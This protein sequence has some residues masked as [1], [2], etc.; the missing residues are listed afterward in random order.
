MDRITDQLGNVDLLVLRSWSAKD[1]GTC[2]GIIIVMGYHKCEELVFQGLEVRGS[3][4]ADTGHISAGG[5]GVKTGDEVAHPVLNEG[6][7]KT[8]LLS[9]VWLKSSGRMQCSCGN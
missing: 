5:R 9:I 2:L 8:E 1:K 3:V 4:P 6:F 7:S